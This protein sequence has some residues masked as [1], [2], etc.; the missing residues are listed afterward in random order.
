MKTPETLFLEEL[1]EKALKK[2]EKLKVED[3]AGKAVR[4]INIDIRFSNNVVTVT[5]YLDTSYLDIY[6]GYKKRR[7]ISRFDNVNESEILNSIEQA[8]KSGEKIEPYEYYVSLPKGAIDYEL[9]PG[10]FD[11]EL[12]N[13][14]EKL[15]DIVNGA[16]NAALN[17]GAE[18]VAG[19]FR[20]R[21]GKVVLLT[22]GERKGEYRYSQLHLNVR[23]FANEEISGQWIA[24]STTLKNLDYEEVGSKAGRLATMTKKSKLI[25]PGKYDVL[26]SPIVM[27]DFLN[28]LAYET[29]AFFVD[30][31]FSAFMNKIGKKVADEKI[32]VEDDP[33]M[34]NNPGGKP[35]DDEGTPTK[36]VRI[37]DRG[38]LKTFLH[39]SATAK[40]YGV[41]S[42]GHAGMIIPMAHSLIV[43]AGELKEEELI[44][45]LNNGIYITNVWYTRFNNYITG[46]FSSMVRDAA[47][48]VNNGEISY[49]VKGARI[50]DSILRILNAVKGIARERMWAKW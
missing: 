4:E 2:A 41:E 44:S 28:S 38:I 8:V 29:S 19:I 26:F 10:L 47:F 1:L 5:N 16:I 23:A 37:I 46:E 42:T 18:R 15:V 13:S 20:V 25:K 40:K 39:N 22:S 32:T 31:G 33:L 36:N 48:A 9:I 24:I 50:S 45:E 12:I 3:F 17:E 34:E 35:F 43:D 30:A 14:D 49:F 6:L 11:P 21:N 7:L 27:G